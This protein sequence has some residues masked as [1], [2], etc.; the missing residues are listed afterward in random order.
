MA[1]P[2]DEGSVGRG[3]STGWGIVAA[4]FQLAFSILF[5]MGMGMLVDRSLGTA[6]LFLLVGLALG[7]GAGLYAFILK[8]QAAA[9]AGRGQPRGDEK[10]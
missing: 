7:L 6:P 2:E 3:Y 1:D 8:V 10:H 5:F 4:G 9:N